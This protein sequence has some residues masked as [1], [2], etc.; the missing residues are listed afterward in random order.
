MRQETVVRVKTN[1]LPA[2]DHRAPHELFKELWSQALVA[3]SGAEDE[4]RRILE[5]VATVTEVRPED[6]QRF[7]R[8]L[9]NSLRSQRTNVERSIEDVLKAA[10]PGLHA[11]LA[12]QIGD[13]KARLE[14]LTARVTRAEQ[15]RAAPLGEGGRRSPRVVK[16]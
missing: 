12:V 3:V 8:E 6:L 14:V 9:S 7:G 11:P 16:T 4:A 13:I 1:E 10:L 5:R 2:E 15:A